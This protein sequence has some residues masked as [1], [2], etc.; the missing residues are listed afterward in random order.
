MDHLWAPCARGTR[1][2]AKLLHSL[3]TISSWLWQ[4]LLCVAAEQGTAAAEVSTATPFHVGRSAGLGAGCRAN[5]TC[6]GVG[7]VATAE[8]AQQTQQVA[9]A[10]QS[11]G[12]D[13]QSRQFELRG[14]DNIESFSKGEGHWQDW[15]WTVRT[16]VSGKGSRRTCWLRL[17]WVKSE[18]QTTALETVISSKRTLRGFAKT[19]ECTQIQEIDG[20]VKADERSRQ[21]MD[22]DRR[23]ITQ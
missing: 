22:W 7:A 8:Q 18:Q 12:N 14:F 9:V 17:R 6:D 4:A 16:P 3:R 5:R 23:H 2:Q 10:P 19:G 11:V 21:G 15:W 1:H 20:I 13:R